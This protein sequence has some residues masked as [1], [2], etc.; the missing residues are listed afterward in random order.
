[1]LFCRMPKRKY[2]LVTGQ[3]YHIYNRSIA[4]ERIFRGSY[5]FSFLQ[6]VDYMRFQ[7]L[8]NY[9]Q[10]INSEQQRR[11]EILAYAKRETRIEI[12]SFAIMPTHFHLLA[13]QIT[14]EGILECI[15][16]LQMSFAISYNKGINR[17][18]GVFSERFKARRITS[19]RDLIETSRYIHLNPVRD[20][21]ITSQQLDTYKLT[22]MPWFCGNSR[23]DLVNS[24]HVMKYFENIDDYKQFLLKPIKGDP[25]SQTRRGS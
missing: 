22:S 3:F 4:A 10:Y 9:D 6:R 15:R 11:T 12:A 21:I 25:E 18:G 23:T 24:D 1:M 14:A 13:L 16:K 2:P 7:T 8:V 19:P 20:S 5:A 17:H